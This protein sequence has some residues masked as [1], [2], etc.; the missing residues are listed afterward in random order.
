MLVGIQRPQ[1]T[2]QAQRLLP[3]NSGSVDPEL[4]FKIRIRIQFRIISGF[5]THS[6]P[7][8]FL[9]SISRWDLVDVINLYKLM[10]PS[11]VRM[12]PHYFW[13]LDP[14]LHKRS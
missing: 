7:D 13:K 11:S 5:N 9:D 12:D 8:F 6:I 10:F 1:Q 2:Q 14:G 3:D 4:L